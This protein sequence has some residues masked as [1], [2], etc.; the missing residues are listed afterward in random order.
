L[1]QEG[2][3]RSV[4]SFQ[5]P[6]R[7]ARARR[8]TQC[9][10]FDSGIIG[11]GWQ[12]APGREIPGLR[13]SI[14]GVAHATLEIRLLR[15]GLQQAVG[16]KRDV[17]RQ[18]GEQFADLARLARTAGANEQLHDRGGPRSFSINWVDDAVLTSGTRT[19]RPP[20]PSTSA[21]PTIASGA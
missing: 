2:I 4:V 7:R 15:E 3:V 8:A 21:A 10:D 16:G 12:S 18:A 19:T 1:E 5:R 13:H 6:A 14:L 11:N 9:L 20:Q 17:E